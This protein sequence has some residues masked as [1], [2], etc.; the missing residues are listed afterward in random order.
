MTIPVKPITGTT[1]ETEILRNGKRDFQGP[2][3]F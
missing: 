3:V 1:I 2:F